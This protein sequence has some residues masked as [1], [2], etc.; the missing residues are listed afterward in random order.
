MNAHEN[1]LPDTLS[2]ARQ[3]PN[4]SCLCATN[5]QQNDK[6]KR[7]PKCDECKLRGRETR[8]CISIPCDCRI[9]LIYNNDRCNFHFPVFSS[10]IIQ[11]LIDF[12]VWAQPCGGVLLCVCVQCVGAFAYCMCWR[13][14]LLHILRTLF[15]SS[16]MM[17][18]S[19]LCIHTRDNS[20]VTVALSGQ[21]CT[22]RR[23]DLYCRCAD[24]VFRFFIFG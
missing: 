1:S 16:S 15:I 9:R 7:A 2:F 5:I 12:A 8:P 14:F 13:P 3:S 22:S 20:I 10:F 21:M 19:P 23:A 4:G 11:K 6:C 17:G 18:I 24:K